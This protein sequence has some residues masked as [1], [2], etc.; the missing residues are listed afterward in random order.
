VYHLP[1][2]KVLKTIVNMAMM[3]FKNSLILDV[4]T[5][6]MLFMLKRFMIFK[7]TKEYF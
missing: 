2:A 4:I 1:S 5:M 3:T 7:D 6:A